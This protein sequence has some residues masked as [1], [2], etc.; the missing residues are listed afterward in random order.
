[1]SSGGAASSTWKPAC[2]ARSGA[3]LHQRSVLHAR[4]L[5]LDGGVHQP[6]ALTPPGSRRFRTQPRAAWLIRRPVPVPLREA[7]AYRPGGPGWGASRRGQ[8]RGH[9]LQHRG[10]QGPPGGHSVPATWQHDQLDAGLPR[11]DQPLELP[12]RAEP[13]AV[14]A[15]TPSQN[16]GILALTGSRAIR[17]RG[18][19][20]WRVCRSVPN[21]LTV[22]HRVP[23][24]V[25]ARGEVTAHNPGR[26]VSQPVDQGQVGRAEAALGVARDPPGRPLRLHSQNCDRYA[27]RS[28]AR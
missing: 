7:C 10:H 21:G 13:G 16:L 5:D 22:V 9:P 24:L 11:Q 23:Q 3:A 17:S 8:Q 20:V 1:M 25:V 14:F 12:G 19:F 6:E 4:V 2:T 15:P 28:W 26:T 27:D 18:V